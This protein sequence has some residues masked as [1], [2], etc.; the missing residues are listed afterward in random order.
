MLLG[1]LERRIEL[2]HEND[3]SGFWSG[4]RGLLVGA[5]PYDAATWR[6]T[7]ARLG[8]QVPDTAVYGY[9]PWVALALTPLALLPLE[10]AGWIWMIGTVAAAAVVLRALLRALLP[11]QP[12]LHGAFGL[13]LLAAQPGF[14]SLVLGQW[15]FVLLAAV[16][17]AVLAI[18]SGHP[19]RA[20]FASL[21]LLAKPQLFVFT[22]L[23]L[24]LERGVARVAV[25]AGL[26]IVGG[27]TLL[28]PQWL[29]TWTGA[30]APAR[31]ARNATIPVALAD[32]FGPAGT[33]L[34]YA[35]IFAG[36]ALATR[37][38]LRGDA[39]LAIW[40]AL[41]SAGAIYT[42]SYDHLLLLVPVALAGSVLAPHDAARA[43]SVVLAALGVLVIVS[44]VF[45][46]VA[47]ARH[48]ES[49]SA[50]IPVIVFAILVGALWPHR[51]PAAAA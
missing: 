30:V 15:T 44:P 4:A 47:V 27:A 20:A 35:A 12:L 7:V 51:R 31:V 45:Y 23:R 11:A 29:G 5:D 25:P 17:A 28:L 3:F 19:A 46:A 2:V 8:T 40:L 34:G 50:V 39:S 49:F 38:G 14:H 13:A 10:T 21:A 48:R 18:R 26:L 32:L 41:S 36:L 6:A 43:R 16:G 1:P 42:W 33:F 37:F 22:A 24:G 9:F